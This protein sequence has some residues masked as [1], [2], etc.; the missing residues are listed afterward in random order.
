MIGRPVRRVVALVPVLG[1][2]AVAV[3]LGGRAMVA[4]VATGPD[5]VVVR[6]V[7]SAPIAGSLP[8]AEGADRA[9]DRVRQAGPADA[10][11]SDAGSSDG[12]P[13]DAGR[14]DAGPSSPASGDVASPVTP[15]G[16]TGSAATGAAARPPLAAGSPSATIATHTAAVG[17][18]AP[19]TRRAPVTV[20]VPAIGATGPVTPIGVDDAG[21]IEV[22]ADATTLGW[23]RNG[24]SPG[25]TGSAVIVG[26]VDFHGEWGTF[27]RLA[28]VGLG[29]PIAVTLDDGSQ[30]T[31]VVANVYRVPKPEL[32]TAALFAHDGPARLTLI[33]CGGA[34]DRASGHY[35]DNVVV[36]AE[37]A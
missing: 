5:Q 30:V 34:F 33:T 13:S 23:Y 4:D 26:H 37:R 14:S 6:L 16:T 32:P 12:A 9:A 29:S 11:P 15:P 24:P 8:A 19:T 31:F 21:E 25:E 28:E 27:G 7:A 2:M 20:S 17:M 3:G 22:P 10:A 35:V 36:E 18:L 1:L